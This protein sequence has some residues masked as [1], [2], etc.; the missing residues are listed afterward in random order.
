M[1][2]LILVI[3][4]LLSK[5]QFG[6]FQTTTPISAIITTI[7]TSTISCSGSG[8]SKSG[9]CYC[10]Y[11]YSGNSCYTGVYSEQSYFFKLYIISINFNLEKK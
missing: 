7:N 10:Y 6:D 9:K 8:I 3:V 2:K 4:L 5:I 1:N 11:G